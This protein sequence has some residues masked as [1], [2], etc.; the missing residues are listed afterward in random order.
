MYCLQLLA[1]ARLHDVFHV[2]FLKKFHGTPPSS[3][4]LLSNIYHGKVV[5]TPATVLRSRLNHGTWEVLI[6][7]KDLMASDKT[8]V[9]R[10]V[11]QQQFHGFQLEDELSFEAGVNVTDAFY[12][13]TYQRMKQQQ[14]SLLVGYV[15]ESVRP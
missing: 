9:P 7:W 1:R 13:R 15:G 5:P 6:R 4:P 11:F 2:V 8:W 12:G 10:S 3:L 14:D